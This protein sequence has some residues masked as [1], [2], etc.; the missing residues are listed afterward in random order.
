[1]A[2][3]RAPVALALAVLATLAAEQAAAQTTF[4]SNF[5]PKSSESG[6]KWV[7]ATAFT[8]GTGTYTL[9]S[10]DL[11]AVPDLNNPWTDSPSVQIYTN[12]S[13][14]R[15]G[16]LVATM[17]NPDM[18][19]GT[20]AVN[21]FTAPAN[22]TLSAGT[23]YW[24]VTSDAGAADGFGFLVTISR[25]PTVDIAAAGW[26]MGNG[27]RKRRIADGWSSTA[28]RILFRIRGYANNSRPAVA[29]PI[30]DRPATVGAPF[31]D[32]DSDALSYEAAQ[33][34]DTALPTWLAFDAT[35]RTFSGTPTAA[36]TV[37]VKVTANDGKNGSISDE[38]DINID[39]ASTTDGPGAPTGLTATASG[40]TTINLVWNAPASDGGS[41]ITGY[42]IEVS[43]IGTFTDLVA[44]TTSTDT[45]YAHTG[46][47]A[48]ATRQYRVSAINADGTGLPSNVAT[49]TTDA[50]TVP[51]APTG[52]T[53]TASG[54][55]T[56]NL[57]WRA[58][59]DNGGS[60]ILRYRVEVSSDGG[61]NWTTL[62]HSV[63]DTTTAHRGLAAGTTR[64]YRV[65]AINL[66]G[67]GTPSEVANAT[68]DG[69]GAPT[70]LT[71]T[72]SGYTTINLVWNAPA[73]DGGSP[74]T[75][76]KIEVSRI[77]TFTDLVANTTSTD[78]TYAHTGLAAGATRQY[79]VS[80]I[81]A[82]GTGLPSNVA[83]ATTDAAT[84]PGAPTGL[85]ATASG[86]THD[87]PLVEGPGRQRRVGHL[88]LQ[89]RGLLR[90]RLQ[91]DHPVPQRHRHHHCPPRPRRRHHPP[92]PRLGHQP[93]RR[94]HPLRGRQRHHRRARRPDR[95]HGDGQRVHHDQPRLERAGKRRRLAHHRLQD[96]GLAHW[97]LYRPGRQHTTST[98]TTYAHTGLAAGATRQYRVSAINADGTGLPSNVAT[99][100]TD[101]ATVPGAPTGLTATASGTTT[102]NLSWR[103]PG[104]QRRVGHLALQ[105]RG[106]LRW[107]L[108]LDPPCPTASPTPPLPTAASPPAPPATTASRPSTCAAS[109]PPPR[110]PTP[111]QTGPAPRP[112]LTATASGYTTINLVW[113]APASDGGSPITGYK[114]EVS[115][116]GTFTDLVANTTSTDTT[117]AHTGLAAGATRQYPRLGHQR[118]R[119][120]A[121]HPTSAT[122]TT[123]AAHRA[124][125][126]D[127]PHGHGQRDHHDQPLVEGPGRQRRVGHL[128]LQGRGL[129]RWRLQ[130]DHPV[131]QRHRHHH[132]PPRPRRR[133]H[134]P[135][136]RLRHQLGRRRHRLQR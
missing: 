69:P 39:S 127:R 17:L 63:T 12:G 87:Q 26:S 25:D 34:D 129:L 11:R 132:C 96:R 78:T 19:V 110:S 8:T 81:N 75:G 86:T 6:T 133:H 85:T 46:L 62:S 115:R 76:Y 37:S 4:I 59:V 101:A 66:R 93:A 111:P 74:I 107:R 68:T 126:P 90:W 9:S 102:I 49:A 134:P 119:Q 114:I 58:P 21:T 124:R 108:Q 7:R 64:H 136:P 103:A 51:G 118:R 98:D 79:R 113:N 50:A 52:L 80:A 33:A 88:A 61:S 43:R 135:L 42:K 47:A 41:P 53:A 89:G 97:H 28:Y 5:E 128:A 116:I 121:S 20:P 83:T 38:F 29:N 30:P 14:N 40:Y 95:P 22:T 54:T 60:V 70:G 45:T 23:T 125:R 2:A 36:D 44:N 72:A 56:I 67:V 91:L 10:V 123:D 16:T 112:A 84:V 99:A 31:S 130:L 94:R 35:T 24:L 15:P 1:M 32:A 104:R 100:T 92:L 120:P 27:F 71:A 57:S 106:L 131:P 18:L 3:P 48:G 73:S 109:A 77:G 122:A 117:Y 13:G 55:T 105:G 82:D 65:S